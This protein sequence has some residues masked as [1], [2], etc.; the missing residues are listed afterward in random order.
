[1][2]PLTIAFGVLFI[3]LGLVGYLPHRTSLTA[4]IPAAFGVVFILLGLVGFLIPAYRVVRAVGEQ[5]LDWP[6]PFGLAMN[7]LF[8]LA[9]LVFVIL[10][11]KSFVD[12]RRRRK[13]AAG[14]AS[15]PPVG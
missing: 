13:Q 11:V 9:S 10:C 4:L 7:G 8:S 1:M 12:A 2:G 6:P 3:V 15:E 14:A 5:G